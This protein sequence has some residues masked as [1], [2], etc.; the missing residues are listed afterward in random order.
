MSEISEHGVSQDSIERVL[1][2]GFSSVETKE[3]VPEY[4]RLLLISLLSFY[5]CFT[6]LPVNPTEGCQIIILDNCIIVGLFF[7][8]KEMGQN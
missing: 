4:T 6:V 8:A 2:S 5:S 1:L 3:G 7:L